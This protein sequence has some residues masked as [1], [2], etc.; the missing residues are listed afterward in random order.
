VTLIVDVYKGMLGNCRMKSPHGV[1][2]FFPEEELRVKGVC[3]QS[4]D[5][6]SWKKLCTLGG[7]LSTL[8]LS[9]L[10]ESSNHGF[11]WIC[12][13]HISYMQFSRHQWL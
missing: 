11:L 9:L 13:L 2:F 6:L 7:W 1:F 12:V 10:V 3:M 8:Q 4:S 5:L